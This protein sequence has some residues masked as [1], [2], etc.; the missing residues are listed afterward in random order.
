MIV[1]SDSKRMSLRSLEFPF[2]DLRKLDGRDAGGADFISADEGFGRFF[3]DITGLPWTE[4]DF[5]ED[6]DFANRNVLG[7]LLDHPRAK[8]KLAI[9]GV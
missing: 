9:V 2:S 6:I 5:K 4:I 3:E 1:G 7:K 8:P